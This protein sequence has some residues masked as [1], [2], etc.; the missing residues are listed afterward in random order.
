MQQFLSTSGPHAYEAVQDAASDGFQLE[1]VT[2]ETL[3]RAPG[4]VPRNRDQL[5]LRLLRLLHGLY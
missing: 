3:R 4:L 2:F 1:V 5:W